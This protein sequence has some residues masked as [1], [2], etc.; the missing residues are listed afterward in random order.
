MMIEVNDAMVTGL[1][2][3][4]AAIYATMDAV[5]KPMLKGLNATFE[6]RYGK[7]LSSLQMET[8]WRWLG[9]CFG[10]LFVA[11]NEPGMLS[12]GRVWLY[13][14]PDSWQVLDIV[15]TGAAIGLGDRA[16]HWLISFFEGSGSGFVVWLQSESEPDKPL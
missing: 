5:I 3:T 6:T 9:V 7:G 2:M 4:S 11:L 8:V 16:I 15:A 1:L 13:N 14:I 10:I 12:L